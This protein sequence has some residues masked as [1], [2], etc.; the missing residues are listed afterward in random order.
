MAGLIPQGGSKPKA[1]FA[2][3]WQNMEECNS[4]TAFASAALGY[5][6]PVMKTAGNDMNVGP[7][8]TG[9][10]FIGISLSNV[11]TS[12]APVNGDERYGVGDKLGVAD[13]G[14]VFVRA[15]ASAVKGNKVWYDPATLKFHGASATGRLPLEE[16]E[17]DGSAADGE[18][19]AV[20]LR[21]TPG[22]ANVTAV[23]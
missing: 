8:T 7:L 23:A 18:V 12:G 20:R 21:I 3:M 22:G 10:R 1:G 6:V 5:G 15:G 9:N 14:V 16:I 19:V 2:G 4:F 17:F 13:M 11:Y